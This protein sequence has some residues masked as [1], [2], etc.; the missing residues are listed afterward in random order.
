[1]GTMYATVKDIKNE[2]SAVCQFCT[3]KNFV[4]KF[5]QNKFGTGFIVDLRKQFRQYGLSDDLPSLFIVTCWH[6]IPD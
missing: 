6:V 3:P 4:K 2:L 5:R 1:M